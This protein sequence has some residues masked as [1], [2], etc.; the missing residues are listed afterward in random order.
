MADLLSVSDGKW[1]TER[2]LLWDVVHRLE[3]AQKREKEKL[4][5]DIRAAHG[6]IRSMESWK[7]KAWAASSAAGFLS[8]AVV[9]LLKLLFVK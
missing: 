4:E 1:K 2:L 8:I 6:K 7:W 3:D 5:G 9:E